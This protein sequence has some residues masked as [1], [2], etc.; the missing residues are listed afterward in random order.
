[1]K[2]PSNSTPAQQPQL[3]Q[4][5]STETL[6]TVA[7]VAVLVL[8]FMNWNAVVALLVNAMTFIYGLVGHNFGIALILF[9]ILIRVITWPLNA[10]QMKGA[11][12]MQA[13][14]SA[15]DDA[16]FWLD[17]DRAGGHAVEVRMRPPEDCAVD[18]HAMVRFVAG[19][20]GPGQAQVTPA[21]DF[22]GRERPIGVV[23]DLVLI[24]LVA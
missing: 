19:V 10:Q 11:A 5:F 23:R 21:L 22:R 16:R 7:V 20:A 17:S 4:G 6:K 2:N 13:A 1:M 15:R 3:P 8:A 18:D 14:Q 9:T 12:A 24:V